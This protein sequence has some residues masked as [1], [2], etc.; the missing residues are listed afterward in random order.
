MRQ[1]KIKAQK[2]AEGQAVKDEGLTHSFED[3]TDKVCSPAFPMPKDHFI[4]C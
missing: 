4:E 2:I 3:L 1:N